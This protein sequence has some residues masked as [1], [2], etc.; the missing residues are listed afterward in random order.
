[1][2]GEGE[3]CEMDLM[4]QAVSAR[5][6]SLLR[7]LNKQ[8]EEKARLFSLDDLAARFD[9]PELSHFVPVTAEES[10][11]VSAKQMKWLEKIVVDPSGKFFF[12]RGP[13]GSKPLDIS[14]VSSEGHAGRILEKAFDKKNQGILMASFA[15][16]QKMRQAGHPNWATATEREGRQFFADLNH[17]KKEPQLL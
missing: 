12:D 14:A 8:K 3:Q 11:P 1:M 17:K 2:R 4:M 9:N 5:E 16:R 6:K 13:A 10:R 7:A 15:V